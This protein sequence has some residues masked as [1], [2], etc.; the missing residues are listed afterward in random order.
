MRQ[1]TI[2]AKHWE[3]TFNTFTTDNEKEDFLLEFKCGAELVEFYLA[4]G[5]VKEAFRYPVKSG[6]FEE[7]LEM[8]FNRTGSARL[9]QIG[10]EL[11][12][13]ELFKYTQTRKLLASLASSPGIGVD[14]NQTER[15]SASEWSRPWY[16]LAVTTGGYFKSGLMPDRSNIQAATWIKEYLDTIVSN[17]IRHHFQLNSSTN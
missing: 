4:R 9:R 1:K 3:D 15:F 13:S 17:S 12:L 6:E 10:T 14:L 7:A 5:R 16:D 8:L 11:E 2:D